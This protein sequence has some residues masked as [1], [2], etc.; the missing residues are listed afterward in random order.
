MYEGHCYR[1]ITARA[2]EETAHLT[3]F[4]LATFHAVEMEFGHSFV[5]EPP[6]FS[7]IVEVI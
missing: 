6:C 4:W 1:V 3:P 5:L 7:A 2:L